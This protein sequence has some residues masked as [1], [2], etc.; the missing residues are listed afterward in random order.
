MPHDGTC[1]SCGTSLVAQGSVLFDCPDCAD[2][3]IGRCPQCRDQAV[4]YQCG[5]CGFVGP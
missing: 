3:K 4:D 5:A 1:S 2:A